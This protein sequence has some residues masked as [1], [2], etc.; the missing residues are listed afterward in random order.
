MYGWAGKILTIDLT[1]QQTLIESTEPFTHDFI[2]GRGM[3]VKK[4]FDELAPEM[5]P[6]DPQNIL[7]FG[8]GALTGI[9][10]PSSARMKITAMSPQGTLISS[11]VGGFIAPEIKWAGYDGI[12]IQG[13]AQK[14]VYLYIHN[15][16]VEFRDAGHLWGQ[17]TWESQQ[18]VKKETSDAVQTLCIGPA[19]EHQVSFS[20]ILS[21]RTSAAGRGG[22]GAVMGS[23]NLKAIAV[24]GT[25]GIGI[26]HPQEFLSACRKANSWLKEHP[27][28]ASL[29][30]GDTGTV[31]YYL[32]TGQF[33]M[34]NWED[35]VDW[36][37]SEK[38][39][40]TG[41][42]FW[43][44]YAIHMY[45]CHG[46][47]LAHSYLFDIPGIGVGSSDCAGWVSMTSQIWTSDRKLTFHANT[48]CDKYGLDSVSTGINV[49]FLMALY[50]QGVINEKDTDGI[51]MKRGD[52]EAIIGAIYKMGKQ[53]GFGVW[54]KEGIRGAAKAIGK[55]A[56]EYAMH[57]KGLEIF[58]H[59]VRTYKA[60]ALGAAV[61]ERDSV[62]AQSLIDSSWPWFPKE[63][64]EQTKELYNSKQA[65][66][67]MTY[68]KKALMIW[69]F[70]NRIIAADLLG[71]CKWLTPWMITP[72][73]DNWIELFN[74]ATGKAITED[75]LL[76]AAKRVRLLERAFGVTRG[77]DRKD[78]TLPEKLFKSVVPEG[79]YKGEK[80][81][82]K[83]FNKMVDEY[84]EL[85]GWDK[86]GIPT[87][88]MFKDLNMPSEWQVFRQR[89]EKKLLKEEV[90]AHA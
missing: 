59:E 4:I 31:E 55:G 9:L 15:D 48:L 35:D 21:N 62:E 26:A 80:L 41:E 13:Q 30:K 40:N 66:L 44:K 22:M 71:V 50:H 2:G 74:L 32:E 18:Q 79:I 49:A 75:D 36:S 57:V 82:K 61:N 7:S 65:A 42:A 45:Q 53:E 33:Y 86:N 76:T 88:K 1:Q 81:D 10:S 43:D 37:E 69:D 34:G 5:N 72:K 52:A 19:G 51:A 85:R 6:Y 83:K 14:P 12:V 39:K 8:V 29:A 54:F 24:R 63:M 25:R 68:E 16:E 84:Y 17:G 67:P 77:F 28:R 20:A 38:Y 73:F 46:C 3:S 56:E 89:M 70:E 87:E 47:P 27:S 78:D 11:G 90:T 23:K 60:K 58:P 64:E